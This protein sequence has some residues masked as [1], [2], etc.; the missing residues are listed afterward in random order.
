MNFNGRGSHPMFGGTQLGKG[1]PKNNRFR[2]DYTV[3]RCLLGF[4]E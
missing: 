4:G 3:N 2:V 1:R